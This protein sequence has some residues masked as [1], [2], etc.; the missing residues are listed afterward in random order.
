MGLNR[1][2]ADWEAS[3]QQEPGE[4]SFNKHLECNRLRFVVGLNLLGRNTVPLLQNHHPAEFNEKME[5]LK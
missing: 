1:A 5:E 4:N 2:L 3:D